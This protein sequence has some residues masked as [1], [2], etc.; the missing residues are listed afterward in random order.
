MSNRGSEDNGK[1]RQVKESDSTVPQKEVHLSTI[2]SQRIQKTINTRTKDYYT[3]IPGDI[4]SGAELLND[5]RRKLV[6]SLSETVKNHLD[7][8]DGINNRF[9]RRAK[10][11][12]RSYVE[13]LA[14][15]SSSN[16]HD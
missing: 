9:P 16:E 11:R 7:S 13:M 8:K 15:E 12:R 2:K 6:N 10:M 5:K 3:Y 14:Q 4:D 1:H